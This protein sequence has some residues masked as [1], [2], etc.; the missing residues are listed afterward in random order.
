MASV[1]MSSSSETDLLEASTSAKYFLNSSA[2]SLLDQED[3]VRNI[4][5]C[6][7]AYVA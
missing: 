7:R 1:M 4:A 3:S 5:R 6:D 2:I